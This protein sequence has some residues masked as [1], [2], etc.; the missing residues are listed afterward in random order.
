[1]ASRL[2]KLVTRDELETFSEAYDVMSSTRK[3]SSARVGVTKL[4][5]DTRV[6]GE[7]TE[8]AVIQG[9]PNGTRLRYTVCFFAW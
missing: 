3:A 4:L 2:W 6:H 7:V 1:V 8:K 5:N 9:C